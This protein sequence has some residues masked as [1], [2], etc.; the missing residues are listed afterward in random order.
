M[1]KT[2]SSSSRCQIINKGLLNGT[3]DLAAAETPRACVDVAG[4][5]V[6][7][8]LDALN[9]RLPRAIAAPVGMAYLN[10]KRDTLIAKLTF[11]HMLH[12]LAYYAF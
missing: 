9:V 7:H 1:Q 8:C 5:S 2:A 6:N 12:L 3:G 10:S 11:S 4:G